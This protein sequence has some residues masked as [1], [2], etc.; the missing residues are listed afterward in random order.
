MRFPIRMF[1]CSDNAPLVALICLTYCALIPL[2]TQDDKGIRAHIWESP[3]ATKGSP[4][5]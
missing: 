2:I 1:F 5:R 3:Y 4:F